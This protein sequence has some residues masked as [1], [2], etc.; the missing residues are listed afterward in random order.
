MKRREAFQGRN[1]KCNEPMIK[2]IA[3]LVEMGMPIVHVC[4]YVGITEQ[5][6][7]NWMRWGK[8]Y[9]QGKDTT[10]TPGNPNGVEHRP[11]GEQLELYA[12]FFESVKRAQA[13]MQHTIITRSFGKKYNAAW[14]RDMTF[15]ERR[16]RDN[17][18][19][20]GSGAAVEQELDPDEAFL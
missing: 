6:F 19:R 18:G 17:W 13:E 2:E 15:L 11:D 8:D 1:S 5:T 16:D 7:Y 12:T 9:L 20:D 10:S 3:R 14:V 4:G